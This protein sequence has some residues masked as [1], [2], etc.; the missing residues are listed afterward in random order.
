MV[1]CDLTAVDDLLRMNRNIF[2][3]IKCSCGSR[4]Q[5]RQGCR[6]IIGQETTV[7]AGIGDEFF[8]VQ[9]LRIV[10]GLLC[11]VPQQAVRI[12]LEGR[13]VVEQRWLLVFLFAL[14]FLHGGVS[15]LSAIFKQ[16]LGI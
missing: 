7:R 13:Q 5:L 8:L 4:H 1:V 14:D 3:K 16:R 10:Q 15:L 9:T 2:V 6:H 12:T 11:A